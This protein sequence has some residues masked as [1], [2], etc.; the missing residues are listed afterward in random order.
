MAYQSSRNF[1]YNNFWLH[2]QGR[3]SFSFWEI[4]K[5]PK[6]E[7][8]LW[9]LTASVTLCESAILPNRVIL[10]ISGFK[11]LITTTFDWVFRVVF[12][13]VFEEVPKIFKSSKYCEVCRPLR[14]N[15]WENFSGWKNFDKVESESHLY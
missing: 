3:I 15:S 4:C 8:L 9:N 1:M 14:F 7:C 11:I 12:L 13:P 5:S 10:Y 2:F 6:N